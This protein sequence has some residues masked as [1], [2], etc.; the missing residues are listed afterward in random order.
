MDFQNII[1]EKKDDGVALI[2]LNRP[3]AWHQTDKEFFRCRKNLY[4]L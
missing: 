4:S 1:A 2:T 3:D